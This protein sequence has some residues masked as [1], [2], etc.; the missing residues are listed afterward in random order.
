MIESRNYHKPDTTVETVRPR[1]SP[2][3]RLP[4]GTGPR[5]AS[6][7]GVDSVISTGG[8]EPASRRPSGRGALERYSRENDST[9][10]AFNREVAGTSPTAQLYNCFVLQVVSEYIWEHS[11]GDPGWQELDV[12]AF[13]RTILQER[14]ELDEVA[15]GN[16]N[17][18]LTAFYAWLA[19]RGLLGPD[20]AAR[21]IRRLGR[22][23]NDY[24]GRV[25]Q[26]ARARYEAGGIQAP[27]RISKRA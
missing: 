20:R 6:E 2:G 13:Q 7:A 10:R 27:C 16:F 12:D 18:T 1:R 5:A 24:L 25:L 22:H 26:R 17:L 11:T 23:D 3:G 21:V 8:R 19:R 4:T 9:V 15:T 14:L